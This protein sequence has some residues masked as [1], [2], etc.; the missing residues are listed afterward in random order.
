MT[1][2]DAEQKIAIRFRDYFTIRKRRTVLS[3]DLVLDHRLLPTCRK[4]LSMLRC[5][6]LHTVVIVPRL[7]AVTHRAS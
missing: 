7:C 5:R 3:N 6:G 1:L 4:S 2:S